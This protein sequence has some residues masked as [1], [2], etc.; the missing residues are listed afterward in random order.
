MPVVWSS[1][2]TS[3]YFYR[4]HESI[5]TLTDSVVMLIVAYK[6]FLQARILIGKRVHNAMSTH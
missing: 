3:W 2:F 4:S 6:Q 1:Y 5:C